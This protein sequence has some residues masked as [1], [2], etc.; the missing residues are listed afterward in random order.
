MS[1]KV[2]FGYRFV[3]KGKSLSREQTLICYIFLFLLL[4]ISDR[5]L[6]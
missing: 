3:K 1:L 4:G 6:L 2:R 5:E